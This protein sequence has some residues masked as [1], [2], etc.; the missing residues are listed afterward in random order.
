MELS[1]ADDTPNCR[2]LFRNHKQC[3]NRVIS[4][5]QQTAAYVFSKKKKK[6]KK[7]DFYTTTADFNVSNKPKL[8][9]GSEYVNPFAPGE[10]QYHE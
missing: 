2:M 4:V 5:S 3:D 7:N 6:K 9:V 8:R 1:K 10:F